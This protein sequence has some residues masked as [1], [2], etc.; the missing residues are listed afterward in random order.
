MLATNAEMG[1]EKCFSL[2]I[3]AKSV[4]LGHGS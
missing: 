1:G 3:M 2:N 4:F